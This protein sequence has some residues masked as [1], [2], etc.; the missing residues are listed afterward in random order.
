MLRFTGRPSTL[1]MFVTFFVTRMIVMLVEGAMAW[2]W[3]GSRK[4]RSGMKH[5]DATP[6]ALR[7]SGPKRKP[8]PTDQRTL[9]GSGAQPMYPPPRR[10]ATQAGPHSVPGTQTQPYSPSQTHRP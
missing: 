4:W 6:M 1:T 9:G 2:P 7:S 8:A 5:Q 10:Q 3:G